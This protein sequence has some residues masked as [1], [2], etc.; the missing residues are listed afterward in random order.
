VH[1]PIIRFLWHERGARAAGQALVA[2][3]ENALRARG[4]ARAVAFTQAFRYPFYHL[5][6]AYVSNAMDHVQALL[7]FSGYR[8]VDGEVFLDWPDFEPPG[9]VVTGDDVEFVVEPRPGRGRLPGLAIRA[10]RGDAELGRCVSVSAAEYARAAD[11]EDWLFTKDLWVA[12]AEQGRGL[13]KALLG[14]SLAEARPLGYR[15]AAISTDWRNHRAFLF[16][17]NFGY[18]VVDWTYGFARELEG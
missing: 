1:T 14:R 17:S 11:E 7:A 8:R 18:A 5:G 2:A 10:M 15:H 6:Y 3:A 4:A 13:G 9:A 12:E 16:Y